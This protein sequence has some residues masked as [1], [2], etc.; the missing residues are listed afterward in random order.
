MGILFFND[1]ATTEIYSLSLHDA[2][3]IYQH[4]AAAVG[5][6]VAV[7]GDDLLQEERRVELRESR[8]R[9]GAVALDRRLRPRSEEHTSELQSRQYL[10]CPLSFGKRSLLLTCGVQSDTLH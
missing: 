1:A 8:R 5:D 2:L 3:P 9:A 10:T 6:L 7:V 4:D